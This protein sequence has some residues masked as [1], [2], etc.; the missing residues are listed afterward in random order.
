MDRNT[1]KF[2]YKKKKNHTGPLVQQG[3]TAANLGKS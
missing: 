3:E 2:R 1:I